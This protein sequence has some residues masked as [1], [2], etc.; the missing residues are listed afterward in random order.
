MVLSTNNQS[1]EIDLANGGAISKLTLSSNGKER[2][3]ISPQSGYHFESSFLFP[4][5]NRLADGRYS[6]EGED[7]QFPLNDFGRPNA[8]H[9]L[10]SDKPF[11]VLNQ[12]ENALTLA[13]SYV[14]DLS[15][16][17]CT[18]DFQVTYTLDEGALMVEV[19]LE[20]TGSSSMPCGFGWH[21]Y[22]NL[23]EG[24][25]QV[26]VELNDVVKVCVD[27]NLIPTGRTTPYKTLEDRKYV[28]QLKLDDCFEF[29]SV[30]DRKSTKLY[31]P[32]NTILEVW[33]D[34]HSPYLQLFTSG[35]KKT[36]AIEPM[37]CG[38]NALNTGAGLKVLQR[39]E[40]WSFQFGVSLK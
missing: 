20:N 37:T 1:L 22:F 13:Y 8:L 3:V 14:G 35:D 21:P 19:R 39:K 17:P 32:D 30:E 5:P 10:I 36:I 29:S 16:F 31:F 25:D 23:A 11:K 7:F 6:F 34:E 15:Y 24:A 9:G 40:V 18:F 38:I 27:D 26:Q 2:I 28:D 33:Q 12:E 4:F